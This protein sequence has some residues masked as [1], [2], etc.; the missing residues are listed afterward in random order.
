MSEIIEILTLLPA[1][2]P[3]FVVDAG[4]VNKSVQLQFPILAPGKKM[5]HNQSGKTNFAL[6]DNFRIL[7]MGFVFPEGFVFTSVAANTYA[8]AGA[9]YLRYWGISGANAGFL[10]ETGDQGTG[11]PIEN[12]EMPLDVFVNINDYA[13]GEKFSLEASYNPPGNGAINMY[14]SMVNAP[15]LL[16]GTTQTCTLFVK[17]LHNIQ[18]T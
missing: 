1:E 3:Y 13:L 4:G 9:I 15:A 14:V 6:N 2:S 16:N 10:R 17:V 12:Y 8:G 18:L 11:I 5:L 7:S